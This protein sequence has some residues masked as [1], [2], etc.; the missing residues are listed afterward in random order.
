MRDDPASGATVAPTPNRH[1]L[2]LTPERLVERYADT[3]L[4]VGY[5]YLH[6]RADAEDVCQEVF[7]K[8][9]T[10]GQPFHSEEHERAWVIR[11]TI[12]LCKDQLR[13]AAARPQT[14]LDDAP[15]PMAATTRTE[16]EAHASQARVLEAV[17]ALPPDMRMAIYLHYYES[18]PIRA[19]ATITGASEAA[20]AKRLSRARALLREELKG[21]EDVFDF[22]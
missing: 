9:L 6:S 16:E 7:L 4:R 2:S 15:E 5:T 8:A 20:V 17:M 19:I 3:V 13:R 18:Y 22:A 14:S 11:V 12:N 10:R 21:D 1:A